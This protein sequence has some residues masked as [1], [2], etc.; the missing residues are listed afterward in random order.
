[1]AEPSTVAGVILAGGDSTR[2]G[3]RDKA[4]A[5]FE[6]RPLLG[7]VAG[8]VATRTDGPPLL[9]V[10]TD[11][12]GDRLADAI[13]VPVDPVVD[14]TDRTGPLAGLVAAAAATDATWLLVCGCDMP[15]VSA[16]A[17][18]VLIG[19]LTDGTDAVVPVVDGHDQ[20]LH[21]LYRRAAISR[22]APSLPA[23]AGPS[24]LLDSLE[25]VHRV[26]DSSVDASLETAVTNVNTASDLAGLR[27]VTDE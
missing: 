11:E 23:T 14:A 6:G 27:G 5:T 24:A 17:F 1:M 25:S 2:F 16:D 19:A 8:A 13:S 4:L 20:P 10:A 12:E 9:A 7:H 22:V 15:L 26:D 3:E 18:A 21:A